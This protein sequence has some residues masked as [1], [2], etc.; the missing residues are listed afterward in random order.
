MNIAYLWVDR[1]SFIISYVACHF[2]S[3]SPG[4]ANESRLVAT[5]R[6]YT[7]AENLIKLSRKTH[8]FIWYQDNIPPDNIPPDNIPRTTPPGQ[9]P[10]DNIPRTISPLD[11]IPLDNI[12]PRQYPP[13][14]LGLGFR[15]RVRV[16]GTVE[17]DFVQGDIVQGAGGY[18][19][20]E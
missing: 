4:Y 1:I 12:P 15:V 3:W 7:T 2:L 10:P 6:H 5:I 14:G 18:C 8:Q 20:G 17:G 16:R 19:P 11:N 13:L 9:Y